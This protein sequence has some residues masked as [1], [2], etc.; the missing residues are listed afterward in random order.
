MWGAGR[1]ESEDIPCSEQRLGLG[2]SLFRRPFV[3]TAV[4]GG[5][6]EAQSRASLPSVP[7]AAGTRLDWP[8]SDHE[9]WFP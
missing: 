6:P 8:G 9:P 1:E 5:E 4:T 2:T 3:P 7:L